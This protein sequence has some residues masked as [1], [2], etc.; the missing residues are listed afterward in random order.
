MLVCSHVRG[1]GGGRHGVAYAG[2]QV[3]RILMT[4][5][6]EGDFATRDV[7]EK[8][9]TVCSEHFRLA[10][11]RITGTMP[12]LLK[13]DETIPDA[14]TQVAKAALAS[15]QWRIV[16]RLFT[17]VCNPDSMPDLTAVTPIIDISTTVDLY[18]ASDEETLKVFEKETT[19]SIADIKA[20][21][22][23]VKDAIASAKKAVDGARA[24]AARHQR[25]QHRARLP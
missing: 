2:H 25:S 5:R 16:S 12:L 8:T 15:L 23:R 22:D 21:G 13:A 18:S 7:D 10:I 1:C 20:V 3:I 9:F 19:A 17:T 4:G 6:L 14:L 24:D 11:D